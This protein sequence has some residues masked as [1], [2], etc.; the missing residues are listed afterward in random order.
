MEPVDSALM[1]AR[2]QFAITIGFH[3]VLAAFSIGL[4]NFLMVLEA[5]WLKTGRAVYLDVYRYWLKVFALNV[6]VGTASGLILEYQFGLNWSRLAVQAG[7][8]IGPLMF[9]EVLAAFF[10]EAGFLGIMLFGLKK[11]GPKLHFFATCAVALGSLISAF[12]ILSAN[13]WMQTPTGY[14]IAA[15]GRFIAED[16]WA[17]IFNPS[18]PYRLA[19]M[20]LAV[21]IGSATFIAGV[22]AWQL[23]KAAHN[24]RARVQFS[25][26][27]WLIVL[28]M[29]LQIVVGDL[30]GRHSLQ[31]QPQKVAAI[32]GSWTRPPPGA[33]EPLRLLAWPDMNER[34]N[35]W[36]L[37]IPR[38]GSLYLHHDL[39]SSIA[40]LDEFPPQDIPPVAPVFFAF[41]L[42]VGLGLLMLAQGVISLIL[43]RRRRLYSTRWWLNGCV[44]LAPAGFL[45]MLSGWVVTEVGR[46][47]FTVYGLMRT[48]DSLSSVSR[49]Q[50]LGST[51]LI[52]VF[53]LL[54]FAIGLW[55]L[56]RL[57]REPP[58][59]NE[60][61]PQP[62]LA[63]ETGHS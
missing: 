25:M 26:S 29:P 52:L 50:V 19:H 18:F 15:D 59:A 36:E 51:W 10:I 40:A 20:I 62:T 14:S 30:H 49:A 12:W 53:Y 32:E 17:I 43:R 23:R 35:L 13:S 7:D 6:A 21:F 60:P 27:L 33:G 41:R 48:A 42:M 46:Q 9:Y 16:W 5:L 57:L 11:V 47:P 37:S 61:G 38:A 63:D 4:A 55:V 2:G 24:P 56:L 31:V 22:S 3:I 34:R 58:H 45:A 1:A 28:L 8:V 44:W 54:I 39:H